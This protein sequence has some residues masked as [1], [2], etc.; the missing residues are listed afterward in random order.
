[1]R[2]CV[3]TPYYKEARESLERC[4]QSVAMQT[5]PCTHMLVSDGFPQDFIDRHAVRHVR[6]GA[7]HGDYGDT[8]RALGALLAASEGV[9]AVAFLDADNC[10]LPTHI[11]D[12]VAAARHSSA[13][14]VT[15]R[16]ALIAPDM[17]VL[18]VPDDKDEGQ[19][20][21]CDSNCYLITRPA[22]GHVQRMLLKPREL[23]VIG[24][25]VFWHALNA[26]GV[27]IHRAANRTVC[28]FT[29]WASHYR[30]AGVPVPPGAKGLGAAMHDLRHWWTALTPDEK[31]RV[32]ETL[33]FAFELA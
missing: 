23:S 9:D 33:G 4:M 2:V 26:A 24:D 32:R 31:T 29:M 25:R 13:Q 7:S 17:A 12:M 27:S 22:F 10:Y 19:T 16:R 21:F 14:V 30:M 15:S 28:Y 6:L 8:P 5:H 11:A 3:V 1:M 18:A 20:D